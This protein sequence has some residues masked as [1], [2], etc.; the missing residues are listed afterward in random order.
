MTRMDES[1][2]PR[3]ARASLL[4]SDECRHAHH[5]RTIL[6]ASVS[7]DPWTHP[8]PRSGEFDADPAVLGFECVAVHE[9]D[10]DAS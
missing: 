2:L 10:R 6:A 1:R 5:R 4:R 9:S 7:T 3:R 8:N